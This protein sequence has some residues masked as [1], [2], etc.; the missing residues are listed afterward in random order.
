MLKIQGIFP[1]IVTPF[2][3]QAVSYAH[4]AENIKKWNHYQLSGYVLLGSNGENVML[5][6]SEAL[7]SIETAVKYIPA[8]K[9]II[10]GAGNE[11]T[12]STIEFIKQAHRIGGDAAL[13]ISSHYYK[14]QMKGKVLEAYF[15]EVAEQSP[16]PV[17]LYNVP[18]FIGLEIPLD[19]V[20]KLSEHANIIGMKDS[21]G[22]MTYFQSIIG[23]NLKKFQLLTGTAN[24]LM[25]SLVAG[26]IGGVL[27]LANI[28][29]QICLDIFHSVRNDRLD[30]ARKLQLSVIRL[31]Q[32]T[33]AVYGI[34]GLK[35]ALD[36]IGMYGGKPRQPL[37]LPDDQGKS[38]IKKELK[39]LK[40]I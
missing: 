21:S 36:Q 40:L 4:L 12:R 26:A 13:V 3:D 8:D 6:E 17:I 34:G 23:F 10:I 18:K 7:Q 11:S 28:A 38:E 29:P 31:N 15:T 33:T 9:Q 37:I 14:D 2:V 24:T 35:Y 22:N 19:T 27:A 20:A 16:L 5:K 1:P 32:L 30:K 39:A 25:L